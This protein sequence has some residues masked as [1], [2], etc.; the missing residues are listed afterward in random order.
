VRAVSCHAQD[1]YIATPAV[2]STVKFTGV[3]EFKES[4]IGIRSLFFLSYT[5]QNTGTY[6]G[7]MYS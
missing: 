6:V 4:L 7:T 1:Q 2:T 5:P 3:S